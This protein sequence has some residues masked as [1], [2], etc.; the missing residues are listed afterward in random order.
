MSFPLK[1]RLGLEFNDICGCGSPAWPLISVPRALHF[2]SRRPLV[3][4]SRLSL[5]R[6][7]AAPACCRPQPA[8]IDC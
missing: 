6:V 2:G 7:R 5:G 1:M 4:L 8:S 3:G